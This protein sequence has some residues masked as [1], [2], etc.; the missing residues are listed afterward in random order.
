[1]T[2][3]NVGTPVVSL[4]AFDPVVHRAEPSSLAGVRGVR[5]PPFGKAAAYL[6][7]RPVGRLPEGAEYRFEVQQHFTVGQQQRTPLFGGGTYV[8]SVS[9]QPQ[10]PHP[11][12]APSHD[13]DTDPEERERIEREAEEQRLDVLPP[14]THEAV[15]RARAETPEAEAEAEDDD[16]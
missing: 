15:K 10:S 9:G 7:V 12:F 11:V 6:T 3:S 4:P 2:D 5:L 1:M 8:V 14:W 13:P 16:G